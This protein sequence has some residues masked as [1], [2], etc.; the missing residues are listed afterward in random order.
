MRRG[1]RKFRRRRPALRWLAPTNWTD[2][3]WDTIIPA[4]AVVRVSANNL[5]SEVTM[6][7]LIHGSAPF[8]GVNNAAGRLTGKILAEKV[9]Y[10]LLRVVG[11]M[12]F[13]LQNTNSTTGWEL[14]FSGIQVAL[15]WAIVRWET[16]EDGA[17]NTPFLDPSDR[18]NQDQKDNILAQDVWRWELPDNLV[19]PAGNA[20]VPLPPVGPLYDLVDLPFKRWV[21]NEQD[22]F[23]AFSLSAFAQD[24]VPAA[25]DTSIA[26][27]WQSNLRPLVQLGR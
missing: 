22:I 17:P 21:A 12:R 1:F 26:L 2:A 9:R 18:D 15:H 3:Q 16:E 14:G 25:L 19:I 6:T 4:N 7:N 27:L 13:G 23:L 10:K 11:R 8:P 20:I 5:Q 24:G